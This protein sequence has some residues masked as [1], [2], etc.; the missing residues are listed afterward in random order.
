MHP[1]PLH[2][3][4]RLAPSG[5]VHIGHVALAMLSSHAARATG[6]TFTMRAEQLKQTR[7]KGRWQNFVRFAH[8]NLNDLIDLG[9][10]PS[11]PEAFK[12]HGMSPSWRLQI[13]DDRALI[14]HYWHELGF[15]KLWGEWPCNDDPDGTN[16]WHSMILGN[17]EQGWV[18]PYVRFAQLV[19]EITTERNCVIRGDDHIMDAVFA[20]AVSH[21]IA[22]KH[23]HDYP[24]DDWDRVS[25]Y[26]PAQYFLPK[27]KRT[28]G[29]PLSSSNTE[30]T[31]G[32]YV[33]DVL[34]AGV[35]PDRLFRYL[36]K[37]LF[38]SVERGECIEYG[39][40][41]EVE[42]GDTEPVGQ[43]DLPDRPGEQPYLYRAPD[44][45]GCQPGAQLV[46]NNIVPNPTIN[47]AD[48]FRFL[49]TKE[50]E[51]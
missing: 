35:P 14:D 28:S 38:G 49:E 13:T 36:G 10:E 34:S 32:F 18:H 47:D 5:D 19:G 1:E 46:M 11:S 7:T 21:L 6:G 39:W 41:Q 26:A 51:A 25:R 15:D 50:I 37:V 48:W 30:A 17:Y 16:D 20:N 40:T 27:I 42:F 9:L 31:K 4:F 12:A 44:G 22:K 24:K 29:I 3:R 23:F 43:H 8:R 45:V 33:R 2:T